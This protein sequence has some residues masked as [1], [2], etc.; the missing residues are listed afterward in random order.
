MVRFGIRK[1]NQCILLDVS[2]LNDYFEEKFFRLYKMD[3][4]IKSKTYESKECFILN[5]SYNMN[6]ICTIVCGETNDHTLAYQVLF[7]SDIYLSEERCQKLL[8][9][10]QENVSE[11]NENLFMIYKEA[12]TYQFLEKLRSEDFVSNGEI[13]GVEKND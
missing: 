5:D 6:I 9:T 2:K 10:F 11:M 3:G 4:S 8:V 12:I 1:I 13:I 7:D